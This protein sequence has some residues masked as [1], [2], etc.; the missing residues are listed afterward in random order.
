MKK[1]LQANPVI[2]KMAIL[3]TSFILVMIYNQSKAVQLPKSS[4]SFP[5]V[6]VKF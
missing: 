6:V 5:T 2:F 4:I 3:I 1:N